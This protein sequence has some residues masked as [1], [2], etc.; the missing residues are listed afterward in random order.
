MVAYTVHQMSLDF[1]GWGSTFGYW[2]LD[3]EML[4][5]KNFNYK[6]K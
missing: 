4:Y 5:I 6:D 1:V 3:V 2:V